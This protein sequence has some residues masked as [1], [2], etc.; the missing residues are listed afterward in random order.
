MA[1]ADTAAEADI[2]GLAAAVADIPV[3]L[4]EAVPGHTLPGRLV[5]NNTAVAVVP[6]QGEVAEQ[7]TV[8]IH[9]W[10]SS[11]HQVIQKVEVYYY[12][13][14]MAAV[15]EE[16]QALVHKHHHTRLVA[17][18]AVVEVGYRR[19]VSLRLTTTVMLRLPWDQTWTLLGQA[20][21][22]VQERL[23]MDLVVAVGPIVH[24]HMGLAFLQRHTRHLLEAAAS[25]V[26][27]TVVV[28]TADDV[29]SRW[30]PWSCCSCWTY[31]VARESSQHCHRHYS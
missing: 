11:V 7:K 10:H 30:D 28:D 16:E 22:P 14:C 8:P 9:S 4:L 1:V 3:H 6:V 20:P 23:R 26:A 24:V 18:V 21:M 12:S 29:Q 13:G 27:C 17:Q 15:E 5:T 19:M 25:C 2:L 31:W